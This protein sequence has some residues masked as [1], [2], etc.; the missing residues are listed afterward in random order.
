[1]RSKP[2]PQNQCRRKMRRV[3]QRLMRQD[4]DGF[5]MALDTVIEVTKEVLARRQPL[6]VK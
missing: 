4:P 3:M 5:D 6:T 2:R 1:M